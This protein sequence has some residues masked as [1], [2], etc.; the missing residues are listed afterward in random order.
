MKLALKISLIISTAIA[1]TLVLGFILVTTSVS[2]ALERSIGANQYDTTVQTFD[3]LDRFLYQRTVDMYLLTSADQLE[4]VL[5]RPSQANRAAIINDL[6]RAKTYAGA[7]NH[8][9]V[10]DTSGQTVVSTDTAAKSFLP[11]QGAS[12]P[13]FERSVKGETVASDVFAD[14]LDGQPTMLFFAPVRSD[15]QG[16]RVIGI[17]AGKVAWPSVNEILRSVKQSEVVLTNRDGLIIGSNREADADILHK[18]L[19]STTSYKQITAIDSKASVTVPAEGKGGTPKLMSYASE[20]GFLTYYG[21]EWR[22]FLSTPTDVAFAPASE[23]ARQLLITL[24]SVLGL[25]LL[26]LLLFMINQVIKPIRHLADAVADITSGDWSRRVHIKS[27]DEIGLLGKAFNGMTSQLA[28]AHQA[29]EQKVVQRTRALNRKVAELED[30]NAKDEAIL[31]SVGEGLIATDSDGKVLMINKIAADLLGLDQTKIIGQDI[32]HYV[33]HDERGTLIPI[34]E[35]PLQRALRTG[36]K[37]MQDVKSANKTAKHILA[38]TATPVKQ[39]DRTIGVIQIIRD[40]TK[41]KEIDRMKTEFISIASH[42]LRTPLSA[43]KWFTEILLAED[44]GKLNKDQTE[45]AQNVADSTERMIELVN[46]LLNI[47][48]IESGRIIV[49]P[50]PTDLRELVTGI[51]TDLKGKTEEK[52]Q[53]LIISVHQG[54]PKIKLDPHLIGQVYLNLLTN[55]IKYTPKGGEISVTISR[56]GN[57]VISQVTDN[58][59]GIPKSEQ[60]KMFK[61]FFRATNVAKVE[62]DGTGLGMYLVKSIIESSGGRIWFESE[63]GKGTTFWFTLPMSGMKAKAGEVTLNN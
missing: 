42:Q 43:I 10:L 13:L 2:G 12:R 33:L 44:A 52:K 25:T 38:I 54:L 62:V 11:D 15:A 9:A 24:G 1:G 23:A 48:R 21:N 32:T 6:N 60:P 36:Q 39:Q 16:G 30:S 20:A 49:D 63:E 45:Y 50:K 51:I 31:G 7:W 58:G 19:Q 37:V 47:S 61:K 8:L 57:E 41:E 3:K 29:L 35:R 59:Y 34:R 40:V 14:P 22:L 18:S 28:A 5:L 17:V 53:T 4:Q 26:V 27:R 56:K 46:S 55:A